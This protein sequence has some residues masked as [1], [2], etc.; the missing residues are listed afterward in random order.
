MTIRLRCSIIRVFEGLFLQ[1]GYGKVQR[2]WIK[3]IRF[4]GQNQRKCKKNP[5]QQH[6]INHFQEL[7]DFGIIIANDISK[8]GKYAI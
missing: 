4:L 2:R 1:G 5:W 8:G 3:V 6:L 7:N